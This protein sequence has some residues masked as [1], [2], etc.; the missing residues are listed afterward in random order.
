M[1]GG[2]GGANA[3]I[4]RTCDSCGQSMTD[5]EARDLPM[6]YCDEGHTVCEFHLETHACPVCAT[7][8]TPPPPKPK[9]FGRR[10]A[11]G[12][13]TFIGGVRPPRR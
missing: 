6:W 2:A 5:D 3:M 12:V 4:M 8:K 11:P 7:A 13:F 10:G 1:L 9:P